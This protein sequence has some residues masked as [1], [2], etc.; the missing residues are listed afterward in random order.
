MIKSSHQYVVFLYFLQWCQTFRITSSDYPL[1]LCS[2]S[3]TA[4][5][6]M[7]LCMYA[8]MHVCVYR[9]L[10]MYVC[11]GICLLVLTYVCIYLSSCVCRSMHTCVYV[12]TYV[13][14]YVCMYVCMYIYMYVCMYVCVYVCMYVGMYILTLQPCLSLSTAPTKFWIIKAATLSFFS[15]S[16]HHEASCLISIFPLPFKPS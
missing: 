9:Y 1:G 4:A 12:C 15:S 10:C 16:K 13:R 8:C 5:V 3:R 14:M 2:G 11:I 7:Y 6:S